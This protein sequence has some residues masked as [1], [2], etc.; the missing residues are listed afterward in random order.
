MKSFI[1]VNLMVIMN[2]LTR[3]LK[4]GM[5]MEYARSSHSMVHAY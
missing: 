4:Y 5:E 2:E 1:A 3:H